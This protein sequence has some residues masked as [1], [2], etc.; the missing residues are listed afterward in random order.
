MKSPATLT[1]RIWPQR[2]QTIGARVSGLHIVI[3]A[4]SLIMTLGAWQFS[5][6]QIETRTLARFEH[7]RDSVI[8]LLHNGM[9]KYEDALWA[10]VSAVESHGGDMTLEEWRAFAETLQ[11]DVKYPGINGIGIIH[12]VDRDDLPTY[13]AQ[14]RAERPEFTIY[15]QHP[16]Q[17]MMPISFIVPERTNKEAIGLDVAHENNRRSAGLASRD[18]GRARITGPITLVQDSGHTPGF[19]F[20]APFQA[21]TTQAAEIADRPQPAGAVYAPFVVR[22]LMDGLLAKER[23]DVHFSITDAGAT[24]YDEHLTSDALSDPDPLYAEQITLSLYGRDWV[25]DMRTTLAFRANNS[26]AQPWVILFGGLVIEGLIITLIVTMSQANTRAVAYANNVTEALQ[27]ESRKLAKRTEEM[28][29]FAYI[30]SHDLRTPIRGIAG[31]T[32]I[33]RDD[34]EPYFSD[35]SA[36]PTIRQ[37]L[38]RIEER[39]IRMNELT[40][41]IIDLSRS[42]EAELINTALPLDKKIEDIRTDFGLTEEALVLTS[43]VR[44][45]R[46]DNFGLRRVLENL[47]GNAIKHHDNLRP[48]RID[49][50]VQKQNDRLEFTVLDNGPGIDPRYHRRIFDVFQTL[51]HAEDSESTGI[52]LAI[53]KKIVEQHGGQVSLVSAPGE[54]AV[55]RFDWPHPPAADIH[56]QKQ[57]FGHAAA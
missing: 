12:F 19:L 1:D 45:V 43:D 42:G 52:G 27:E 39:A 22:N 50:I 38:D 28:E 15:P 40:R 13:L 24:I 49:L 26:F 3:I 55:F 6:Y 2:L 11:I 29:Q 54:G 20:Y 46:Y 51:R 18:S 56:P 53:V 8:D 30:A 41:G 9:H 5:R 36:N 16:H 25:I 23:R 17:L 35:P 32:E 31:L 37:N 47:V 48:L 21:S 44:E 34:L 4:L 10:G 14:R 7:T 57:G 33:L